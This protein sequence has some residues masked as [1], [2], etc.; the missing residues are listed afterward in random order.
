MVDSKKD[1]NKSDAVKKVPHTVTDSND[2][3]AY[4]ELTGVF[5]KKGD[6]IV[7]TPVTD[8]EL[9]IIESKLNKIKTKNDFDLEL[10]LSRILISSVMLA[11]IVTIL[12]VIWFGYSTN[13]NVQID[14]TITSTNFGDFFSRMFTDLLTL[15]LTPIMILGLGVVILM[16]T[17]YLRVLTSWI[18]FIIK[19]KDYKYVVITSVVLAI[20]TFSL[21]IS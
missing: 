8:E 4:H 17:P 10:V 3:K 12:G 2:R 16:I 13:I 21:F 6:L 14:S 18:F 9:H 11:L 7:T 15:R 1:E 5:L 20:L 19:E